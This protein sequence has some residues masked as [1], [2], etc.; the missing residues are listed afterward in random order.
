MTS[1]WD[2][3]RELPLQVEGYELVGHELTV[4]SSYRRLTTE[5]RLKGAGAEGCGEDV[6]WDGGLQGKLRERG[7]YLDL[8]GTFSLGSFSERLDELDLSPDPPPVADWV[9]YRRW[10]MESAALD[11]ALRQNSLS[12]EAA[13]DRPSEPM[14][15]AISLGPHRIQDLQQRLAIHRDLRFKLDATPDWSSEF[16]EELAG[17]DAVDVVDFKGAYVGTPVD[18]APDLGLYQRVLDALPGVIYEDPHDDAEILA[19]L[20]RRSARVAWDAPIH[21]VRDL[22]KM[23]AKSAALNI[24]P[25]RFGTLARLSEAYAHCEA[26]SL[27]MYGG[28]QFE[29]AHGRLQIQRLAA[30]FHSGASNDVAPRGYHQLDSDEARPAS[31]LPPVADGIGF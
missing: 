15:F 26:E 4:N 17:T 31:P 7:P 1:L 28:G 14:S 6:T 22:Q 10:A 21:D 20:E 13:L 25:S 12:L 29:L 24:K 5:F 19:E 16:C 8:A 2:R 18:V 11:L 9:H 3:V 23:P 27:P 30:I